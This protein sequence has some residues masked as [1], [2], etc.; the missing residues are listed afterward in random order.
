M[1]RDLEQVIDLAFQLKLFK[2]F[3]MLARSLN[4]MHM[5]VSNEMNRT[6]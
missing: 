1:K 6:A 4:L 2:V 3:N 5:K